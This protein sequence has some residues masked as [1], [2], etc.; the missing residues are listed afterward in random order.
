MGRPLFWIFPGSQRS[1]G[2]EIEAVSEVERQGCS[3]PMV[4]GLAHRSFSEGGITVFPSYVTTP[5]L[6]V[7]TVTNKRRNG[8]RKNQAACF[9][10]LEC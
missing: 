5:R 3:S 10:P 9:W 6:A 7:A 2:K 8:W 1:T 4:K